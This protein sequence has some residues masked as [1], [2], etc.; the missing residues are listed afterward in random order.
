MLGCRI[1]D[2]LVRQPRVSGPNE[3]RDGRLG[4]RRHWHQRQGRR[5]REQSGH[6]PR[7]YPIAPS[8][9]APPAVAQYR[10][11]SHFYRLGPVAPAKPVVYALAG[12]YKRPPCG[13]I[14][15]KICD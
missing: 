3:G 4:R 14:E 6:H 13:D 2:L 5:D 10:F 9:S 12:L 11:M 8:D 1:V 7:T 15:V